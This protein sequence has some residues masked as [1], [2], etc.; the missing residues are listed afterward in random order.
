MP[1]MGHASKLQGLTMSSSSDTQL[2]TSS[3]SYS[4][5]KPTPTAFYTNELQ[6]VTS[7]TK[8]TVRIT[9]PPHDAVALRPTVF[10]L[11]NTPNGTPYQYNRNARSSS[12]PKMSADQRI[13]DKQCQTDDVIVYSPNSVDSVSNDNVHSTSTSKDTLSVSLA[14]ASRQPNGTHHGE[15]SSRE[16]D[17]INVIINECRSSAD[18]ISCESLDMSETLKHDKTTDTTDNATNKVV[19]QMNLDKPKPKIIDDEK[20]TDID[21]EQDTCCVKCCLTTL[22]ICECCHIS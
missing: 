11:D 14:A 2:S 21:K 19:Y 15:D 8:E 10:T 7:C 16:L 17:H 5:F 6:E 12:L 4:K 18:D 13:A 9:P 22:Q 3:S 1:G 20:Y